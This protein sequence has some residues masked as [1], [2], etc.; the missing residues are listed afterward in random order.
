MKSLAYYNHPDLKREGEP[1]LYGATN[2]S[3]AH[4]YVDWRRRLA[5]SVTMGVAVA[6]SRVSGANS[7]SSVFS[8]G[9][10]RRFSVRA[11]T[12]KAYASPKFNPA[13][14]MTTFEGRARDPRR[15]TALK[16]KRNVAP[17]AAS[18]TH[19]TPP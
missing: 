2:L 12:E 6:E 10:I 1:Y 8:V 5:I 17:R 13:P 4:V 3:P 7:A 16:K 18:L 19:P 9:D 15:S 14:L 11:R